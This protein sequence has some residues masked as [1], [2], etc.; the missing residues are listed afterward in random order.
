MNDFEFKRR[1]KAHSEKMKSSIASPFDITKKIDETE[2]CNMTKHI[3]AL[4]VVRNIIYSAAGVAA[5]FVLTFNCIP[6]LAY[7]V[8]DIPIL[9]DVVRVVTFGR[10][11][12][13]EDTYSANVVTP[14]IEGLLD[15]EL[16]EKLNNEFCENATAV[17]SAFESDVKELKENYGDNGFHM[18]VDSSYIVRTDNDNIL[19]IDCYI[20]NMAGS[21]STTH[22]FYTINKK[23][24][25]LL[26]LKSLFKDGL[27]TKHR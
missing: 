1:M 4:T 13:D 7:A 20:V 21:S 18:G 22:K 27:I 6:N 24:G 16:E 17:I 25:E 14:K 12:I 26:T 5:A 3:T 10:F 11:E 19:A 8:N 23:T 2:I 15:K 9:N